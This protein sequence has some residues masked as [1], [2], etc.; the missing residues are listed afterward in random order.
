MR[1]ATI[2]ASM[3]VLA[4]CSRTV[5]G[6][7][8][9]TSSGVWPPHTDQVGELAYAWSQEDVDDIQA[10]DDTHD[11]VVL[12]R[13]A[14]EWADWRAT[15]T[16][17]MVEHAGSELDGVTVDGAVLVVGTY[18]KCMEQSR[19]E[20]LGGG[21]LRFDVYIAPEHQNTACAWSPLQVEVWTV[22]LD[23]LDVDS[24]D[25]VELG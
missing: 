5:D 13:T 12:L 14:Q 7:G 21:A 8:T 6:G 17:E 9:P 15:I 23:A 25:D 2:A 10:Y 18:D 3:L 20:H 4:G 24:A 19:I 22:P 1:R 16:A 11:D